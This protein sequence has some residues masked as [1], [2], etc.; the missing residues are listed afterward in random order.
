[1]SEFASVPCTVCGCVC[2]D[3]RVSTAGD[4]IVSAANA[5]GLATPWFLGQN[6]SRPPAAEID[7]VPTEPDAAY[8]RAAAILQRARNPLI[9]GLGRCSTAGLRAAAAL[10]DRLG[11][12]IDTTDHAPSI[13]AMQQVGESTCTLGEVKQRADLVIFWG[14]DPLRT[15]PRL[16]ERY[17]PPRPGR[18]FVV[19]DEAETETTK[20]VDE[21]VRV[22]PGRHWEALWELRVLATSKSSAASGGGSNGMAAIRNLFGRM[23]SCKFGIV[24]YGPRLAAGPNAH[25]VVEALFQLV[26]DLNRQSRFYARWMGPL[27]D[28]AGA[29]DLLTWQFGY[30]FGINLAAGFPRYNPGEFTGPDVLARNEV[31]ACLLAGSESVREFPDIARDRLRTIPMILLDPADADPVVPAAVKFTTATFGIH[32]PG[33]AHRMDN[34]T[35]PLPTLLS[36]SYP[37]D[38]EV[39]NELLKRIA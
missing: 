4:R 37:D 1:M 21:F 9:Y 29:G 31:D 2:D 12:T 13:V 27:G 33:T 15:H 22:T 26:A 16:V 23:K 35:M 39:L 18:T 11:A 5:C 17:C 36:T 19:V 30:P 10:A 20:A 8:A 28:V 34:V 7:G 14:C 3:L 24:F 38:G 6:S 25:R 32:C